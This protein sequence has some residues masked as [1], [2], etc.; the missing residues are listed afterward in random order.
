MEIL[1]S[2]TLFMIIGGIISLAILVLSA[3]LAVKKLTGLAGFFRLSTTFVGVT[4]VSL[5]TSITEI[6]SHY[7]ASVGI[8]S[9]LLDYKVSSGVVLGANIGS[10]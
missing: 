8:L 9:G 3:N 4:V 1:F 7:T 10:M 5:A 6:V 2:N